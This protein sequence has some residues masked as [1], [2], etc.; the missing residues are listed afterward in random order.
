MLMRRARRLV[1]W[2]LPRA[3]RL[4]NRRRKQRTRSVRR[5]RTAKRRR[6]LPVWTSRRSSKKMTISKRKRMKEQETGLWKAILC[7]RNAT[8]GASVQAD[9]ALMIALCSLVYPTLSPIGAISPSRHA[10]CMCAFSP[11]TE[12]CG[13]GYV[14]YL[15][16]GLG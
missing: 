9:R 12:T 2:P 10:F 14:S 8:K 3:Y 6:E 4:R 1:P 7:V 5:L 13:S 15:L 11:D 16:I